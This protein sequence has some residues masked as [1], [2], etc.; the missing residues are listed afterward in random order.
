MF[1]WKAFVFK[2]NMAGC[3]EDSGE[4]SM[5]PREAFEEVTG[6]A[7]GKREVFEIAG[8]LNI[9]MQIRLLDSYLKGEEIINLYALCWKGHRKVYICPPIFS[10]IP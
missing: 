3:L 5:T 9:N 2:Q 1:P 7:D 6:I 8:Q 10:T 4:L